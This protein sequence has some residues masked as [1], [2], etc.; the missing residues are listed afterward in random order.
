MPLLDWQL[1]LCIVL[2]FPVQMEKHMQQ[3]QIKNRAI[4]LDFLHHP[5]CGK[6]N[7]KMS[8][9]YMSVTVILQSL[10]LAPTSLEYN[11]HIYTYKTSLSTC[12]GRGRKLSILNSG[13]HSD[14]SWL[15][16]MPCYQCFHTLPAATIWHF[17][18]VIK[19]THKMSLPCCR[20]AILQDI[21]ANEQWTN[22]TVVGSSQD[23]FSFSMLKWWICQLLCY[24]FS[25]LFEV[26]WK[27]SIFALMIKASSPFNLQDSK[28]FK[29]VPLIITSRVPVC[30]LQI[31][32]NDKILT[33]RYQQWLYFLI[34]FLTSF[35]S[36]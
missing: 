28:L 16:A 34:M 3:S 33:K 19:T 9:Y 17:F 21:L 36:I 1:V 15:C 4:R 23:L 6:H 11:D 12:L 29:W 5:V 31:Q 14:G 27:V 32:I 13:L 30:Q 7:L 26:S 20:L 35:Q 2:Y 24:L 8:A 18:K 22:V 10:S 25:V